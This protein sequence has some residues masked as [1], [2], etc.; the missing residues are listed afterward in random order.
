MPNIVVVGTQWGDE[1][2]G[3]VTDVLTPHVNVVVRYQGGNNAGH[4]VVV[5]RQKYVLHSIP[6]GI[7][8]PG[9]RC[10]IGCGVVVDPGALIEE[11]EAL[12]Q[13]GVALDGNLF[14]SKNAHV[15]MPYHPALDRA[16]EAKLGARRIGTTGKGVGPA[17]VDKAARVGIR[18]ADLLDERLFREKLETNLAQKNRLL[19]EIY[20][21]QTFSVD[22]ILNPYLRYAGWL[23]PYITDTALLLNRWIEAG[24]SVLFEGA[25]ATML[26]LDHGTYPYVTSSSTTAGGA[27]T[28]TGVP[29]TRIHGILGVAKAYT[30]RVGAGPFPTEMKGAIAEEIR[31]RGN[32]YG[33]T[34]GRPRRCGWFDAVVLRY[35]A[36]INGLDTVALTKLDVLDQCETVKICTGYRYRGEVLADFPEEETA[37]AEAEPVY[38]EVSGWMAPTSRAKSEGD[39]PA[40][41]RRYLER[42]EELIG[43]PFCMISTGAQRD[44]TILCEDSP[45]LRW[46]PSVRGS[47][48]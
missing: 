7:L 34:T 40:K 47:L 37:L 32:E 8:H 41:A 42:L 6:S 31:A 29:P 16:S 22:E 13:R 3:K 12:V 33:A 21:A 39:L 44:E 25:Q 2:K 46:F 10:V 11:M 4:T 17:Y 30:T 45:L 19:R 24:Y 36:R 20:D 5:G 43:V 35:A 26:D 18:M 1:G 23:A 15:I 38:E 27:A 9:R 48:L 28:G 14:I